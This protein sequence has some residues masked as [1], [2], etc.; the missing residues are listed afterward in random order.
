LRPA[1]KQF[2]EDER[3]PS[4]RAAQDNSIKDNC[5]V[6]GD[7]DGDE[8]WMRSAPWSGFRAGCDSNVRPSGFPFQLR[9]LALSNYSLQVPQSASP[10]PEPDF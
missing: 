8:L 5:I 1:N 3:E 6:H 4:C 7:G 9:N 10:H 2:S